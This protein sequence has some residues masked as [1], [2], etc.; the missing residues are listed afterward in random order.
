[1]EMIF[2]QGEGVKYKFRFTPKFPSIC[3]N[4][5]CSMGVGS[6][7]IFYSL[8]LSGGLGGTPQRLAIWEIYY[9]NNPF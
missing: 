3:I 4:Q 1:M 7:H 5:R 2:R 9:Q 8:N 6:L